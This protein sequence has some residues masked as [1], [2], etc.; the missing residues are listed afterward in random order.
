[1]SWISANH[2]VMIVHLVPFNLNVELFSCFYNLLPLHSFPLLIEYWYSHQIHWGPLN[3]LLDCY[4]AMSFIF[5]I[6]CTLPLIHIA[7]GKLYPLLIVNHALSL[8][9]C[10]MLWKLVA[11]VPKI[12][13]RVDHMPSLIRVN[14]KEDVSL[15]L[16]VLRQI[17][18][19]HYNFFE[20][21]EWMKGYA[22]KKWESTLNLCVH[23]H[24]PDVELI[25]EVAHKNNY[26]LL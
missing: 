25:M 3:P 10:Y 4:P 1:M 22:L 8:S 13:L 19:L 9:W 26:P 6:S 20:N 23:A 17:N 14:S 16:L 18:L 7:F 12:A 15:T 24:G 11:G 5:K 2:V 21:E